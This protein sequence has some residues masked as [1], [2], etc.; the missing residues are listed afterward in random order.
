V[1]QLAAREGFT[2][3]SICDHDT[4]AGLPDATAAAR[5][6]GLELIPGLEL[7]SYLGKNE[8]HILGYCFDYESPFLLAVLRRLCAERLKR[9]K[10]MIRL[11]GQLGVRLDQS[12]IDQAA[13]FGSV[14][15][16]HLARALVEQGFVR[17]IK[18][19]F[20]RYIGEGKPAHVPRAHLS[21]AEACGIITRVGGIPVLAHPHH[22][23]N[24]KLI[25]TLVKDG[26]MGIEA[27]YGTVTSDLAEHY[28]DV[29][30]KCGLLVTGGSDCHQN[31][32]GGFMIGAVKLDYRYVEKLKEKAAELVA[33]E[34]QQ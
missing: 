15:R 32:N 34:G 10:D 14:G 28:G 20:G 9:M 13:A 30:K 2:A 12:T 31:E 7:T 3:I 21:P 25:P 33:R 4:V 16:L 19:A 17:D 5:K 8:V 18:E 26:V 27:F 24:D 11:L 1:V 22:L 29:A 23:D 6:I